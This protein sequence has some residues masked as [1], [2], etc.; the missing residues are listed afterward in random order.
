MAKLIS[1]CPVCGDELKITRLKCLTCELELSNNFEFGLFD[2]LNEEQLNFLLIFLKHRGNLKSLQEKLNI[3]YPYAVKKLNDLLDTLDL[4]EEPEIQVKEN[5]SMRC[6]VRNTESTKASDIIKSKLAENGGR[7][8]VSSISGNHYGIKAGTDGQH[9]FCDE[10]P[11]IYTYEVFD[12]IVDLLKSQPNF[13]AKK[14]NARSYKLGDPGCK[15]DSVAGVI[16]KNYFGKSVGESGLD[17]VFVLASVL[18]WA[19]IAVNGRGYLELTATYRSR[20]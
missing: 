9:F 10:L 20:L 7:V 16:L 19:G 15:E 4:T 2:R 17:P 11:P 18:E 13:K 12:V 1:Q 3:S 6:W 8:V 5:Q 14:G